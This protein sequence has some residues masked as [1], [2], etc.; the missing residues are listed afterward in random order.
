MDK[1]LQNLSNLTRMHKSLLELMTAKTEH[2]IHD[3]IDELDAIIKKEQK[4]IAAIE[5][6]EQQR[7]RMVTDYLKANGFAHSAAPTVEE[8]LVAANEQERNEIT[9]FRAQLLQTIEDIKI[10]NKQNQKLVYQSLQLVNMTLDLLQPTPPVN[11]TMNYS[12]KEVR[13]PPNMASKTYEV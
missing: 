5:Q 6:L 13:Q 4:H 12:S 1:I 7:Q 10:V 8:L 3:N 9:Q 11:Q 2:L